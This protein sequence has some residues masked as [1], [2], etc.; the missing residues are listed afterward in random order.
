MSITNPEEV[1]GTGIDLYSAAKWSRTT[2]ADGKWLQNNTLGPIYENELILASAIHDT[3]GNLYT[4]IDNLSGAHDELVREVETIEAGSD[5]VDVV[6]NIQDLENYREPVTA[7]DIVKVLDCSGYGYSGEQV[8]WRYIGEGGI[9]TGISDW[10]AVGS[11][12]PYYSKSETDE[13]LR[14]EH[15]K[16]LAA[17][18]KVLGDN[19]HTFVS[20]AVGPYQDYIFTASG[21][22]WTDPMLEI[23]GTETI[24]IDNANH[25]M[26]ATNSAY[27]FKGG[28]PG[29]RELAWASEIDRLDE[30]KLDK[31]D[32]GEFYPRWTNP[33]HFITSAEVPDPFP[34]RSPN[35]FLTT[36]SSGNLTWMNTSAVDLRILEGQNIHLE[37]NA[38]SDHTETTISCSGLQPTL[39]VPASSGLHLGSNSDGTFGWKQ[40][41][42][43]N[44]GTLTIQKNGTHVATFGAN[45]DSNTTANIITPKI[46]ADQA[47][48]YR[49]D[50]HLDLLAENGLKVFTEVYEL[51]D[52]YYVDKT[53]SID[54]EPTSADAGKMFS[55]DSNGDTCWSN[56]PEELFYVD[57]S[58]VPPS[59]L[60]I[61]NALNNNKIVFTVVTYNDAKYLLPLKKFDNVSHVYEFSSVIDMDSNGVTELYATGAGI[62]ST[63]RHTNSLSLLPTSIS[64]DQAGPLYVDEGEYYSC[65]PNNSIYLDIMAAMNVEKTK[66]LYD[67]AVHTILYV[68]VGGDVSS[69]TSVTLNWTDEA[70]F[71]H[72]I[73]IENESGSAHGEYYNAFDIT[74]QAVED[75]RSPGTYRHV[76]RVY[77]L[78][79]AYR[80]RAD[81]GG[82]ASN[83]NIQIGLGVTQI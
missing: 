46:F 21:K 75:P 34:Q 70:L 60:P 10:S 27:G 53:Y 26:Y 22:D 35:Q 54:P 8:Y 71:H 12:S 82:H 25:E 15:D 50:A 19:R 66:P 74:V 68:G 6:E 42:V 20:S 72:S 7:K 16:M 77:D 40:D 13:L 11:V 64:V 29:V 67:H 33:S 41:P 73:V 57:I 37:K 23:Y 69:C 36:N 39:P 32:S 38:F 62:I 48:G 3:S 55:V 56:V 83:S 45:Q 17:R 78:P 58:N 80:N 52:K 47:D 76:A 51:N 14:E 4:E 24:H 49:D 44:D 59:F 1:P 81:I 79:C 43:I 9:P 5:V 18:T 63:R 30:S 65:T 61:L 2:V 28:Y 31:A